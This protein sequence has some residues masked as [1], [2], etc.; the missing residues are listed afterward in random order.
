V[1]NPTGL[2]SAL[3]YEYPWSKSNM[4]NPNN[5]INKLRIWLYLPDYT[6]PPRE[7]FMMADFVQLFL[8][9]CQYNVFQMEKNIAVNKMDTMGGRNNELVYE[10]EPYRN[11]PYRDFISDTRNYLDRIKYVIFMY[12]YW[13]VLAIVFLTGTSR[14]KYSYSLF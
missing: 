10:P 7:S 6:D 14:I 11:N 5:L 12:S 8:A 2:P 4:Q 9:W 3:C 13:I 1:S